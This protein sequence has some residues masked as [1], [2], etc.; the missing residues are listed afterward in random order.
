VIQF[1]KT[2]TLCSPGNGANELLTLLNKN[3]YEIIEIA[4]KSGKPKTSVA[5]VKWLKN[6]FFYKEQFL[7]HTLCFLY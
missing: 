3:F 6:I 5:L 4:K 2:F 1:T 7:W